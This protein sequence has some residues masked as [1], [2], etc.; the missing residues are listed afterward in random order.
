MADLAGLDLDTATPLSEDELVA[1]ANVLFMSSSEP[2][3]VALTWTFLILSQL[4][5]LRRALRRELD[6]MSP[7]GDVPH[8]SR[9]AQLPLLDA[10]VSETLRLLPPN[11]LMVRLTTRPARLHELQLPERCEVVVCPFLAHRDPERFA[12]PDTFLPSR[13]SNTKPSRHARAGGRVRAARARPRARSSAGVDAGV[14]LVAQL[15]A[16][17]PARAHRSRPRPAGAGMTAAR[18]HA[19]IA[20]GLANPQ[21]LARW[22]R[23]PELLRSYGVEPATLDLTALWKFAGLSAKIKH[24][25]LRADLPLTFRLLNVAGLEIEVFASYASARAASGESFADTTEARV[26]DLLAFLEHWLDL[27]RREHALLWDLIRH[28]RALTRLSRPLGAARVSAEPQLETAPR[29]TSV[30]RVCG[31][32]VLHEMRCDPRKLAVALRERSPRL[33][34][35]AAGTFHLC[36]WRNGARPELHILELDELGFY[37]LSLADGEHTAADLSRCLQGGRRPS[38]QFLRALGDL[39]ALGVLTFGKSPRSGSK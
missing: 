23:E 19:V 34:A 1:H 26:Q 16:G 36:Y 37:L 20:A 39:A 3:A 24:N 30:P 6:H 22:Q 25:A 28:E 32:I 8:A 15:P 12:R 4:P 9:L 31:E 17:D 13:W 11:A 21:L 7:D 27:D 14:Q 33:E 5:E 29:A 2:I 35:V 10:V 18:I 38:P